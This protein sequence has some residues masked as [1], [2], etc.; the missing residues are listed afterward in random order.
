MDSFLREYILLFHNHKRSLLTL[1]NLSLPG[2]KNMEE[3]IYDCYL[4]STAYNASLSCELKLYDN[5]DIGENLY[6]G[7]NA[8]EY[9][10]NVNEAL[11]MWWSQILNIVDPVF[12]NS[13]NIL[14]FSQMAWAHTQYVGCAY[15]LC[16]NQTL[17]ICHYNPRGN[18][19]GMKIYEEGQSCQNNSDCEDVNA[20]FCNSITGLCRG[21]LLMLNYSIIN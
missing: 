4:E 16:N 1:G 18:I 14:N 3:M 21:D 11:E 15:Q 6:M 9:I 19:V 12:N 5:K 7:D 13:M 8:I 10:Y 17:F 20:G 2:A